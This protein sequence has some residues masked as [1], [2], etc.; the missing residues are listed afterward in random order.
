MNVITL[1]KR[2][3]PGRF[4]PGHMVY[5]YIKL[6]RLGARISLLLLYSRPSRFAWPSVEGFGHAIWE[7]MHSGESAYLQIIR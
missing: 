6:S 5:F 3:I 7:V 4:Y 2:W 1:G